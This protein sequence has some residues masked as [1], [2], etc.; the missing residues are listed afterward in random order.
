MNVRITKGTD[1]DYIE[2]ERADGTP[3]TLRFPKKGTFPHDAIHIV[4]EKELRYDT[5]FWGKVAAGADPEAVGAMAKA[6]GHASSARA[7]VPETQIVELLHA[8]RI[9]ECFEAELW[10]EPTDVATFQAVLDAACKQS[11][12]T[13]P[14]LSADN[15]SRIREELARL[16]EHWQQLSVGGSIQLEWG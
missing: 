10:G 2:A 15:V 11:K 6:A 16:Q 8:E 13:T 7:D 3:V 9:V 5:A 12:I 1:Q 4:V 14:Q